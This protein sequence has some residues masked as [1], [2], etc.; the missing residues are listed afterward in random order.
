MKMNE[1]LPYIGMASTQFAQVGLMIVGKK[2]MSAGMTNYTFVFYSNA[3][4]S[5][6]LLPS[7]F[8]YRYP[9]VSIQNNHKK[10][11]SLIDLI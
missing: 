9:F 3:L 8:F 2:A 6:I 10:L 1:A 7:F 5:L 4:A 11:S